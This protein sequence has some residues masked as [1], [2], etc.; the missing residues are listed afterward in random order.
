M[1]ALCFAS[2]KTTGAVHFCFQKK[3]HI[4]IPAASLGEATF[5]PCDGSCRQHEVDVPSSIKRALENHLKEAKPEDYRVF[6]EI[7]RRKTD[8][9]HY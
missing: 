1:K 3:I 6:E 4:R 9:E 2:D 8:T 5:G 7:V